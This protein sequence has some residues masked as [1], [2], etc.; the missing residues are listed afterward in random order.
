MVQHVGGVMQ[1]SEPV[2]LVFSVFS[3]IISSF[4]VF[5]FAVRCRRV[6]VCVRVHV[7]VLQL[8]SSID[9]CVWWRCL[10][11]SKVPGRGP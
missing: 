9:L 8:V 7:C 3:V 2:F 10:L 4:V 5:N 1:W 11:V 6:R